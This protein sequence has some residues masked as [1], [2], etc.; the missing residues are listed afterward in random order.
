MPWLI[1]I[2][3]F[4]FIGGKPKVEIQAN[5]DSLVQFP[6]ARRSMHLFEHASINTR[7][8]FNFYTQKT[9]IFK[10]M[11]GVILYSRVKSDKLGQLLEKNR[12]IKSNSFREHSCHSLEIFCGHCL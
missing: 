4:E 3:T 7:V 6:N 2:L 10:K 1:K 8:I 5:C 9:S 11:L 12:P